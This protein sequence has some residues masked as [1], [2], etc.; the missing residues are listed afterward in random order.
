MPVTAVSSDSC[1]ACL[2][3]HAESGGKYE[4]HDGFIVAMADGTALRSLLASHAG[5]AIASIGAP[6]ELKAIGCTLQMR[7]RYRLV[8]DLGES[9]LA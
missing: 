5:W 2:A 3:L 7:D 6:V 9:P 4:S 8:P 1:D